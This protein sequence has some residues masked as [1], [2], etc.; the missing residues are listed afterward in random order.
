[1]GWKEQDHE[2]V[3]VTNCTHTKTQ[4]IFKEKFWQ[5]LPPT[6]VV[7]NKTSSTKH[8]TRAIKNQLGRVNATFT[9]VMTLINLR[10]FK[11][12]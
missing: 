11:L 8:Q 12:T 10:M 7:A 1:M 6:K 5:R 3:G 4:T 2:H 9:Q